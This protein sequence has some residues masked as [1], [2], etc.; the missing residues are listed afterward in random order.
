VARRRR[1]SG[2]GWARDEWGPGAIDAA[3]RA[4]LAHVPTGEREAESA[5]RLVAALER[6]PRPFD[7]DAGPEHVTGS[8]V[9][10]G[11]RGT[12]LHRHRRLHRWL[13]PGGHLEPGEQP[14]EA[15]LREAEEETGLRLTHPGDGPLLIHLDVHQAADGHTHLDL[16]Y[17]LVGEDDDPTPQAGE[18]PDVR[19]FSWEE[20]LAVADDALVGAL[21]AGRRLAEGRPDAVGSTTRHNDRQNE[22][23]GDD[24]TGGS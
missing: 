14:W 16:R 6:L 18:S 1:H 17:L 8:A 20:A 5:G 12:V 24:M 22:G 11:T 15:A 10:V 19:W 13:Q 4:V 7:R 9:V 23:D 2:A 3:R 21:A